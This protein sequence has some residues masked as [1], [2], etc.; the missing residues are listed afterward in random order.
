M[1]SLRELSLVLHQATFF[2]GDVAH[3]KG[4]IDMESELAV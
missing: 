4:D 1:S 3:M 2:S